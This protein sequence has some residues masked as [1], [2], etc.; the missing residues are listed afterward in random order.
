MTWYLAHFHQLLL[1]IILNISQGHRL[2][3]Y[4]DDCLMFFK[5]V[6]ASVHVIVAVWMNVWTKVEGWSVKHVYS[7]PSTAECAIGKISSDNDHITSDMSSS[8]TVSQGSPALLDQLLKK[9]LDR[10]RILC[11]S[12]LRSCHRPRQFSHGLGVS[13]T[14]GMAGFSRCQSISRMPMV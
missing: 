9:Y 2:H 3:A 13:R 1:K 7:S 6:R 12:Y 8:T 4:T 10:P 14:C 11:M 5:R